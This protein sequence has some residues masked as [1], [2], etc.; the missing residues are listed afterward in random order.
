M[1]I[2][3]GESHM[4][5]SG[6]DVVNVNINYNTITSESKNELQ[7]FR[8]GTTAVKNKSKA[9][10]ISKNCSIDMPRRKKNSCESI[11]NILIWR[12]LFSLNV[13]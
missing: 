9:Q 13:S 12:L 10:C 5:F 4:V 2:K 11:C 8:L 7:R 1:K 3:S 6:N